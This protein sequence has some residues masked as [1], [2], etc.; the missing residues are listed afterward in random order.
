MKAQWESG[1][2]GN[3]MDVKENLPRMGEYFLDVSVENPKCRY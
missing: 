2:D 3:L 1:G